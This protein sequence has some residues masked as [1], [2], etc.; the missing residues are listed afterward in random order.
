MADEPLPHLSESQKDAKLLAD[1]YT[2]ALDTISRHQG[3]EAMA[4]E[5]ALRVLQY[6]AGR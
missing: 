2:F 4:H 1:A 6:A 3:D 5:A